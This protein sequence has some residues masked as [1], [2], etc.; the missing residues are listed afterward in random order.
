MRGPSHEGI[1]N[2]T[3]VITLKINGNILFNMPTK[4]VWLE[5]TVAAFTSKKKTK[6]NNSLRN[7]SLQIKLQFKVMKVQLFCG[8]NYFAVLE[9]T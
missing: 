6:K 5:N 3:L 8:Y 7:I 9:K 1:I 4:N 2:F